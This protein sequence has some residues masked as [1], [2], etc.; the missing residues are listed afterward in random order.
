M[1]WV[2]PACATFPSATVVKK[3]LEASPTS[4]AGTNGTEQMEQRARGWDAQ[5][6]VPYTNPTKPGDA[7]L[8]G[9]SNWKVLGSPYL[10]PRAG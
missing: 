10:P 2:Y 7:Q 3:G 4:W 5:S 6:I 1:A 8:D 9:G